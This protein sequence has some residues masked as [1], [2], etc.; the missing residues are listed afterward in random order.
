[1]MR[2]GRFIARLGVVVP[3]IAVGLGEAERVMRRHVSRLE[4]IGG[5]SRIAA[6]R[7]EGRWRG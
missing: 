2:V 5:L 1:M 6:M 7:G 3:V 4:A